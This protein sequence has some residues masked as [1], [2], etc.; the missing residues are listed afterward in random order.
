MSTSARL[1]HSNFEMVDIAKYPSQED[2][3]KMFVYTYATI[4]EPM[5]QTS[6]K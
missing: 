3:P 1:T 2:F 5:T 6:H 4:R